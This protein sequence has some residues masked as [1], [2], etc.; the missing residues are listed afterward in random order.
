MSHNTV[1]NESTTAALTHRAINECSGIQYFM[2]SLDPDQLRR[3]QEI[4]HHLLHAGFE[5]GLERSVPHEISDET[6]VRVMLH[7]AAWYLRGAQE[8]AD[9][10]GDL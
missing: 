10:D 2:D 6:K 4:A 5:N 3:F 9:K 7:E 1:P 8:Y